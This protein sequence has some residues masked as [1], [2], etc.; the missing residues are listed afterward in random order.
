MAETATRPVV[1]KPN[2]NRFPYANPQQA[3]RSPCKLTNADTAGALSMFEL[4][5]MPKTGPVRHL[6]HREDEWCY[7]LT[8][9]FIFEVGKD[10]YELPVSCSIWMPRDIAHVWANTS[11]AKGKLIVACQPG[12]FE[13]FFDE[14]GKLPPQSNETA[15]TQVM[16]K[17]G[18]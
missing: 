14:L 15:I 5:V 4:N 10:R 6:H 9:E 2:E 17:F 1:V 11:N 12:G 8:G 13:K 3:D 7:V 16:A 18:M